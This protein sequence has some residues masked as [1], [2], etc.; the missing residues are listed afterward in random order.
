VK[1]V[2]TLEDKVTELL[3]DV[4]TF[5]AKSSS[6]LNRLSITNKNLEALSKRVSSLESRK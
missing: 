4:K 3:K 6:T 2:T 1:R 5:E